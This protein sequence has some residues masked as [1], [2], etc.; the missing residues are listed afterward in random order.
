[1]TSDKQDTGD[2]HDPQTFLEF[3]R[4]LWTSKV[5]WLALS[6]ST[7]LIVGSYV[8]GAYLALAVGEEWYYPVGFFVGFL[9][10]VAL[11][12]IPVEVVR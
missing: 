1:M 11:D 3:Q 4:E 8:A 10:S 5:V 6:L 9:V 2:Y 7:A 12:A